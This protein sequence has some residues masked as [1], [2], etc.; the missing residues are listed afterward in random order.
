[1][2]NTTI[3]IVGIIAV[4][5][6]LLGWVV[7]TVITY[8]MAEMRKLTAVNQENIVNFTN[9]INHQRTL[10]REMQYS[11]IVAITGLTNEIK[12]TNE[13]NAKMLTLL[14]KP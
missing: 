12:V 11:H 10:D 8:F 7:H 6:T 5:G 3:Q 9:T 1:M 4:I 14:Q 13:I 2:D